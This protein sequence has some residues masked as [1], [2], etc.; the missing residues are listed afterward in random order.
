MTLS[1]EGILHCLLSLVDRHVILSD[2][3]R[4]LYCSQQQ[5]MVIQCFQGLQ[6][7]GDLGQ[8]MPDYLSRACTAPKYPD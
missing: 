2:L 1:K 8:K 6:Q 7:V 4:C 3:A 5:A